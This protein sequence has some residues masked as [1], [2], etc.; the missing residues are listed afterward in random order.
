MSDPLGGLSP[1]PPQPAPE[2]EPQ[3]QR[4][5]PF[6]PTTYAILGAIAVAF[7]AEGLVGNDAAVEDSV[8]LL[9]LGALYLPAV[10]D[11]DWWRL[12]SYAF[13]HIGWVHILMNGWA[14]WILAPQLELTYGS[15][16]T[17]GMFAATALAG[18]GASTLWAI[19]RG[20]PAVMAAGA[21]GGLFGLFGGTVALA[22]RVRYRLPPEAR[23]SVFRRI[24]LT[25]A[26]NV[27]IATQF[28]V[29]SAAHLGG[30]IS[31]IALGLWA[32]LASMPERPWHKPTHWFLIGSALL[33]AAME[34]AAFARAVKPKPRVLRGAGVEATIPGL[35]VPIEPGVAIIPGEV[36]LSVYSDQEPLQIYSGDDAVHIGDRTWVRERSSEKGFEITRLAASEGR[37]RL[38]IEM[39]CGHDFCR[40][41][42]ASSIYELVAR[43]A[44]SLR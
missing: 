33:L 3:V 22:W 1:E 17:M 30:L 23:K 41:D 31:G 10:R 42:K 13:L 26:I 25:L 2:P 32:P 5:R 39:A 11:G 9:R 38:V 44:K 20:G 18:G 29:D 15:N 16:S 12:G 28:P 8:A 14:L 40:G 6:T 4:K 24:L 34:G 37:G 21:S 36:Q 43:T 7:V 27:A 19:F 35:L